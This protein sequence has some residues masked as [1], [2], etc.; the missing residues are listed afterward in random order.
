MVIVINLGILIGFIKW[1]E[2]GG[3][4]G[5]VIAWVAVGLAFTVGLL[6][7]FYLGGKQ[8]RRM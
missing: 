4:E 8:R 2:A 3:L 1:V 5:Y 6:I 7:L